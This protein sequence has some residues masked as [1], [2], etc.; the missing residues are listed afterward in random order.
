MLSEQSP[1]KRDEGRVKRDRD[2][3]EGMLWRGVRSELV[4]VGR[5]L[6]L[7][8]SSFA[9]QRERERDSHREISSNSSN[10]SKR[11]NPGNKS[12]SLSD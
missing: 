11:N 5:F 4:F 8:D 12:I 7:I 2:R 1:S 10:S 3:G 6:S 9:R